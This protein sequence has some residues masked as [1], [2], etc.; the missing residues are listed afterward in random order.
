[1][2]GLIDASDLLLHARLSRGN[3]AYAARY[4]KAYLM[5]ID[6]LIGKKLL[7]IL[8]PPPH[9]ASR[10]L[11]AFIATGFTAA[12]TLAAAC[13]DGPT[14]PALPV[15]EEGL[16]VTVTPTG[17]AGPRVTWDAPCA[18]TSMLLADTSGGDAFWAIRV[19]DARLRSPQQVFRTP[20]GVNEYGNVRTLRTGMVYRIL[21]GVRDTSDT[22][23]IR[24]RGVGEARFTAP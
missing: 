22:G 23:V 3:L 17:D 20:A 5:S 8:P 13:S 12:L 16:V 14:A 7:P 21:L 10:R 15:C 18:V 24:G 4:R 11:T 1:M 2:G 9:G 6:L 19:A